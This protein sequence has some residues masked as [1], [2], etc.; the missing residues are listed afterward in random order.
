M[1]LIKLVLSVA[2]ALHL[3]LADA[4]KLG[5]KGKGWTVKQYKNSDILYCEYN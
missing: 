3:S 5:D 1:M 2:A 4:A